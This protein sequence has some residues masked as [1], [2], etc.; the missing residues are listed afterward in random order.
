[1]SS[2]AIESE[3]YWLK[4]VK[5]Y[6][7][8]GLN[9]HKYCNQHGIV[10]HRFLYWFDKLTP[11]TAQSHM[12]NNIDDKQK[13]Q[14]LNQ[15]I[16]VKLSSERDSALNQPCLSKPLCVLELKQGHRLF[17]HDEAIL[18]KIFLLLSE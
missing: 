10:Y 18:E 4:H 7:A 14:N 12:V 15:F 8:S 6:K 11:Q 17:V 5:A 1:M 13:N 9:K 2:N 3:L 16:K